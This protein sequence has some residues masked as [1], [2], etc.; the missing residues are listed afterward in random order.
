MPSE[1]APAAIQSI[2]TRLQQIDSQP[3][4]LGGILGDS[5]HVYGYHRAR[6][7]LPDT[8]YSVTL[9]RDRGGRDWAASA[10]DIT[11]LHAVH[12]RTLTER[13]AAAVARGDE[14]L[15]PVREFF[16]T[17]DGSAVYGWDLHS[18][19]ASASDSSHLWHV[20]LSIHRDVA[21][22]TV[23]LLPIADVLAGR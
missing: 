10:L 13:L 3:I 12:V 22:R 15:R 11:P 7:V 1:F 9:P 4:Q 23:R 6:A 5:A 19:A 18:Q 14:R 16:G 21:C 20:H 2:F 8:D 17:L